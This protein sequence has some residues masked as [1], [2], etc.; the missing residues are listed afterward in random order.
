MKKY[1][2][3]KPVWYLRPYQRFSVPALKILL[4]HAV[5]GSEDQKLIQAELRHREIEPKQEP[6]QCML[7]TGLEWKRTKSPWCTSQ[8]ENAA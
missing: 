7:F 6:N 5:E 1:K 3:R 2:T 8:L 4:S